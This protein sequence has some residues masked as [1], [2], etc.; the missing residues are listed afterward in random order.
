MKTFKVT[1]LGVSLIAAFCFGKSF[2]RVDVVIGEYPE[3]NQ[4]KKGLEGAKAHL[5]KAD[6]DYDGHRKEAAKY[7]DKAI[8]EIDKAVAWADK[9]K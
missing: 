3:L 9:Q 1:L 2:S 5:A 8:E 7:T 4:A 6:K